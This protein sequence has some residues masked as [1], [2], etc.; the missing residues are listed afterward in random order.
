VRYAVGDDRALPV[1]LDVFDA[2]GARIGRVEET[3]AGG[4]EQEIVWRADAGRV[5]A[6]G[7]YFFRLERAGEAVGASSCCCRLSSLAPRA[8]AIG[9]HLLADDAA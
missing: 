1:R 2:R 8:H 3:P 6:S 9:R 5:A 7:V 4:G